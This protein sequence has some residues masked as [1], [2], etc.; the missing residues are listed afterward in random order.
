M[1]N[2]PLIIA[3]NPLTTR[4]YSKCSLAI[5]IIILDDLLED[6]QR[7]LHIDQLDGMG[8]Y[9]TMT[10]LASAQEIPSVLNYIGKAVIDG[11]T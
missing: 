6:Q 7:N 2:N 5:S 1:I 11:R 9:S 10:T 8:T 3:T 4:I